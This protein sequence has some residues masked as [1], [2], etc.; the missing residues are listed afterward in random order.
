[1]LGLGLKQGALDMKSYAPTPLHGGRRGALSQTQPGHAVYPTPIPLFWV[2]AVYPALYDWMAL[3][4]DR[5][6]LKNNNKI[7]NTISDG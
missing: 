7:K 2:S 3:L 1:M 4:T 6:G 5:I